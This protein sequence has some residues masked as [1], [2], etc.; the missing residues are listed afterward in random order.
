MR[1]QRFR[2]YGLKVLRAKDLRADSGGSMFA[3]GFSGRFGR[4]GPDLGVREVALVAMEEVRGKRSSESSGRRQV[5]AGGGP[6]IS[7]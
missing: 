6:R 2:K 7:A 1:G 4:G 5:G 3:M